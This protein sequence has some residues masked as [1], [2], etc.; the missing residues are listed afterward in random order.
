MSSL[1]EIRKKYHRLSRV[2]DE[3]ARR[4][5]AATEA[6]AAGWGGVSLVAR[7]T[8]M[9]R[10]TVAAGVRELRARGGPARRERRRVRQ[11]G[12]GR[13]RL[14]EHEPKVL[15]A[16]EYLVGASAGS[17]PPEAA[18][19]WTCQST[20]R[21]AHEL[22]RMGY[23]L[24]DRSV[25]SLL[26]GMDYKLPATQ[27]IR[28]G[29]PHPDCN[30]QFE[31]INR[32]TLAFQKRRQPVIAV[33]ARKKELLGNFTSARRE[34]SPSRRETGPLQDFEAVT[35]NKGWV[36]VGT[37]DDSAGFA[38]ETIHRWWR[39]MGRRTYPRANELLIVADAGD[40][41]S[42]VW[43]PGI[44]RFADQTGLKV[45]I[46]QFPPG[47]SKWNRIEHRMLSLITESGRGR[48]RLCHQVTVSLIGHITP[49]SGPKIKR[50]IDNGHDGDTDGT[51]HA[52]ASCDLKRASP[53]SEWNYTLS[54]G[55]P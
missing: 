8:G 30:A 23:E 18:L 1:A 52:D 41:H 50:W 39:M 54:P 15:R 48:T 5:W 40:K 47:T 17:T 20:R 29:A 33:E 13:K 38:V 7:A 43:K 42:P 34:R 2:L 45:S 12:G 32:Q 46:C 25:A 9:A 49:R 6:S 4:I 51:R 27:P 3:R 11:L 22:G 28:P 53:E 26:K 36:N 44:Q 16:L 31:Y 24:S 19:Y 14:V 10:N 37:D 55:I 35:A 21:L